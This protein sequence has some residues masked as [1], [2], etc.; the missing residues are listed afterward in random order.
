MTATILLGRVKLKRFLVDTLAWS[1]NLTHPFSRKCRL[2]MAAYRLNRHWGIYHHP[3]VY[4]LSF[5]SDVHAGR[6]AAHEGRWCVYT[7]DGVVHSDE[8]EIGAMT[9]AYAADVVGR[10]CV[11][12]MDPTGP[13]VVHIY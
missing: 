1:C 6:L 7:I 8:S 10:C 12:E 9:W 2:T 13:H 3:L 11:S 5:W 4:H